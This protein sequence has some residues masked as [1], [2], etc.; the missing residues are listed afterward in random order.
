M[1]IIRSARKTSNFYILDK[2]VS[3]DK[4]LSWGAR[5]LLIFLL[6]KPDHWSVSVENLRKETEESPRPTG[7]DGTYLLLDELMGIGYVRRQQPRN[8]DGT[9][10]N[11][12]YVVFDVPQDKEGPL[13]E[14]PLTDLPGTAPPHT[15]EPTLVST[16][17]KLGLKK[18]VRIEALLPD[19]LPLQEWKDFEEMR[20]KIKKP[21]TDR[22]KQLIV[23][24]LEKL[25][26]SG[27]DPAQ[28]LLAS[29][30]NAWSGVFPMK[31]NLTASQV[32]KTKEAP[33]WTSDQS[34]LKKAQELGMQA[35]AGESWQ[36]LR[37]RIND[38]LGGI[39]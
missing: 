11:M 20:I 23:T 36:E 38:R 19:W 10:A 24:Q 31:D 18:R 37:S 32:A 3:E 35:R 8:P 29:V 5:G 4:R 25:K 15:V 7:R 22:A 1:S 27:H 16:D 17:K 28:V 2:K 12:D 13:P 14:S 39:S 33:W 21:L 34:I 6:G 9:V 26:D 30:V